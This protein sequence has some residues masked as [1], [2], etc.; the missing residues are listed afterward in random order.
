MFAYYG[1][2]LLSLCQ[3]DLPTALPRLE[4]AVGICQAAD[5]PGWFPR[6]AAALG[7]AYTLAGR[8]AAAMPLLTQALEQTIATERVDCQALCRLPLGEAQLLAGRLEEAHTLAARA[9]AHAREYQERGHQAYALRL[10]GAIAARRE[11]PQTDQAGEDYRQALTLA[12]ALGTRP[13]AAHCHLGLGMLSATSGRRA[14]AHTELSAAVELYRAMEMTF[15][16]PQAETALA[17]LEK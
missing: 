16:L 9:L 1:S 3:G 4:E 6:M 14:A 8:V 13:L 7:A 11:P 15:W 17:Q 10:L 2:G 12:K 5:L